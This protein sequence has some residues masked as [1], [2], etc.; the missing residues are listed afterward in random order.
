[1]SYI[2]RIRKEIG[3]PASYLKLGERNIAMQTTVKQEATRFPIPSAAYEAKTKHFIK[4]KAWVEALVG[5]I[6]TREEEILKN[7]IRARFDKSY[8]E[9]EMESLINIALHHGFTDMAVQMQDDMWHE[10]PA[11]K[12]ALW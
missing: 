11:L 3:Q 5:N 12:P 6:G 2:V 9:K 10:F 7:M 8:D 4:R 1:M